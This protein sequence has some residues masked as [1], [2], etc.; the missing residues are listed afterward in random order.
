[1]IIAI[2]KNNFSIEFV[3]KKNTSASRYDLF[4]KNS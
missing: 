3:Y 1:M 2:S 4:E